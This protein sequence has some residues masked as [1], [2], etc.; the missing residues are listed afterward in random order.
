VTTEQV[1]RR[2]GSAAVLAV[3]GVLLSGCQLLPFGQPSAEPLDPPDA[4]TC[5]AERSAGIIDR[6]SVVPC[7]EEH[8]LEVVGTVTWDGLDAA[9][10]DSD[11]ESVYNAIT[12]GRVAA[13]DDAMFDACDELNRQV[14]GIADVTVNGVDAAGM[15]LA[16]MGPLTEFSLAD[17]ETFLAGD[18]T[19]VCAIRW[20][21][22]DGNEI[23]AA[24]PEGLTVA[25]YADPAFPSDLHVCAMSDGSV[26]RFLDCADPHESQQVLSFQGIRTVGADWIATVNPA[27]LSVTDYTVPDAICADL[28]AQAFPQLPEGGWLVWSNIFT[29]TSGWDDFDGTVDPNAGYYFSCD[30]NAP[31]EASAILGDAFSGSAT[32]VPR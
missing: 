8:L 21:D 13:F 17:R 25:D 19:T 10:A 28:V 6:T 1:Q 9:I 15:D 23:A 29:G 12:N 7:D 3:A 5:L 20:T 26:N 16:A 27:D 31:D 14:I 11:A 30:L 22:F 32:I 18:H 2:L 4:G 24:Y